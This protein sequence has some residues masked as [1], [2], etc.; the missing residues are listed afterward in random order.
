MNA[1]VRVNQMSDYTPDGNLNRELEIADQSRREFALLLVDCVNSLA[2]DLDECMEYAARYGNLNLLMDAH[3]YTG[4]VRI[5]NHNICMIAAKFG[6]MHCLKY[7]H[8]HGA[9]W[10]ITTCEN[11]VV[12][13]HIDCLRYAHHN[14]CSITLPY[15]WKRKT[16]TTLYDVAVYSFISF[17]QES[18][19]DF[20]WFV[21]GQ[22]E[23][24]HAAILNA[25]SYLGLALLTNPVF[26]CLVYL[27]EQLHGDNFYEDQ[28]VVVNCNFV[29]TCD[30]R[31]HLNTLREMSERSRIISRTSLYVQ[32]LMTVALHPNRM[33]QW[34]DE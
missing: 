33:A 24:F 7:A 2:R 20:N 26:E 25:S 15:I 10:N 17:V 9:P 27:F 8:E 1:Y 21:E 34:T 11:A 22:L 14:G 12:Y 3:K 4:C 32:E 18:N 23:L 31:K 6:H 30:I 28:D 5:V 29:I 16:N 13:G 19:L